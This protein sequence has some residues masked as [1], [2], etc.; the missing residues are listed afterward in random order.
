MV[1]IKYDHRGMTLVELLVGIVIT[2]I[3]LTVVG[4]IFLSSTDFFE[5]YT[6][7]KEAKMVLDTIY[8]NVEG[9]VMYA[10]DLVVSY[11]EAAPSG[12]TDTED[13]WIG[14]APYDNQGYFSQKGLEDVYGSEFYLRG[15]VLAKISYANDAK[16]KLSLSL[17]Y[18]NGDGEILYDRNRTVDILNLSSFSVDIQGQKEASNETKKLYVHYR[19]NPQ[20]VITI[21]DTQEEKVWQTLL[22]IFQE[23]TVSDKEFYKKLA[24]RNPGTPPGI[25]KNGTCGHNYAYLPWQYRADPQGNNWTGGESGQYFLEVPRERLREWGI[26]SLLDAQPAGVTEL[27]MV[28][29]HYVSN[30]AECDLLLYAYGSY[31]FDNET[32]IKRGTNLV[33]IQEEKAWYYFKVNETA[34][35]KGTCTSLKYYNQ[36]QKAFPVYAGTN[37]T[38]TDS[39]DGREKNVTIS[40]SF[41]IKLFFKQYGKKVSM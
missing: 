24:E 16:K 8:D 32:T 41:Q 34:G 27:F 17:S 20:A 37:I 35:T 40:S 14:F 6:T 2:T 1:K 13:H 25:G 11:D 26:E 29:Y 4:S 3:A 30:T 15:S 31:Y 7:K 28:P 36:N 22:R 12:W 38:Y 18:Q 10:T 33:Y 9:Q 21:A 19:K 39:V 23:T 5:H